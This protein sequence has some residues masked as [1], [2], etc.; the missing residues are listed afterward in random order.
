MGESERSTR[1]RDA[2]QDE[3]YEET[4]KEFAASLDRLVQAYE[5]DPEKR[6]DLSQEIHFQL[7]RSLAR[8][9]SRCSLR[10]WVYR[11]AH[12][13][14]VT[15]VMRERRAL[16]KLVS[17]EEM[18][19]ISSREDTQKAANQQLDLGRLLSMIRKLKPLDRQVMLSYLEGL[20]AVSTGEI[21]GLS[22]SR[23]AM[24]IHR[25]KHLL[26]ARVQK[27]TDHAK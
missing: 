5:A 25:I 22:A 21:T 18:E 24:R 3:R 8:Y 26:S 17:L 10:T 23:V 12:N 14:A 4:V 9:D 19:L 13:V 16:A 2:S 27:G 7:W 6:R 1:D 15:H 11:I 20:D